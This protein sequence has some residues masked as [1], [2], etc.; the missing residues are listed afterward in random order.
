MSMPRPGVQQGN[1][2]PWNPQQPPKGKKG[3]KKK[4][5]PTGTVAIIAVL[6]LVIVG[7]PTLYYYINFASSVSGI[8]GH[9]ATTYTTPNKAGD[10]AAQ[11][12]ATNTTGNILSGKRVNILL[13]GSDNDKKFQGTILAQTDIILTIDPQTKY[14]GML[15][16][17]RDMQVT[18]PGAAPHKLDEVFS[19]GYQTG[20]TNDPYADA[21]GL[22]IAAIEQNFGIPIDHYAWVGL[23]GFVKVIDTAGGVDVDATHPMVD[24][25]YPDDSAGK[26]GY[27]YRR[28]YIA[29]GPQHMD[30][31]QALL[32]VRTRHS[33]LV[34]DFGRSARQQQVLSQLKT[35][36]STPD[37]VSKLPDLLKEMNGFVKTD[38]NLS[39]LV[40][41]ANYARSVDLN[42]VDR[43]V[44][45]APYS[46]NIPGTT[47]YTP[48][49][50]QV[51]PLIT[52]M[53]DLGDKAT[54]TTQTNVNAG[55]TNGNNNNKDNNNNNGKNNNGKNG[56][57]G[58]IDTTQPIAST[59][60]LPNSLA[61]ASNTLQ[62]MGQ[63]AQVSAL[64]L[65]QGNSD[66]LGVHSILDI[67]FMVTFESF[68]AARV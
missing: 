33:D 17:P 67:M 35:K 64:N 49:C 54:C 68:D 47:N 65:S 38:M 37:I 51:L 23:N 4:G 25:I 48:V 58:S 44:L 32:Y 1:R 29:P 50:S 21:A 13:L 18:V 45:S 56:K 2:P 41:M 7:G 43:K 3:G 12:A 14:V 39:D 8:T 66:T 10:G 20:R 40:A 31:E 27:G 46:S 57:T 19:L 6:L 30:G 34:G 16:I 62:S 53:F 15:S 52:K 63:M 59:D 28:L 24:D 9:K 61:T 36:L 42:K 5:F 60:V 22:S 26:A 55:A 11:S